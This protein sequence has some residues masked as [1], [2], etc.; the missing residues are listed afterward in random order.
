MPCSSGVD[1]PEVFRVY[2]EAR[3]YGDR[4]LSRMYYGWIDENGRADRCTECGECLEKCPQKIAIVE[5]LEKA[6]Q[7]L[8]VTDR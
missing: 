7:F 2:N 5:W 8:A 4:D 3:V 1:I 6:Q